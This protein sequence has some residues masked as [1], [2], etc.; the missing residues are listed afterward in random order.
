MKMRTKAGILRTVAGIVTLVV[1]MTACQ[2]TVGETGGEDSASPDAVMT[3]A[4]A[5]GE[6]SE[7]STEQRREYVTVTGH[8]GDY[9][10]VEN[11]KDETYW[12]RESYVGD[13]EIDDLFLLAYRVEDKKE[14][15]GHF[16]VTPIRKLEE[17]STEPWPTDYYFEGAEDE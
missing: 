14:E 4:T 10:I 16:V 6:D 5:K 1:A 11:T 7:A 2:V 17:A 9:V 3:P 8:E 15:D 12:I 13:A